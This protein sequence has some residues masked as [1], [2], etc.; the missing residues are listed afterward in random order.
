MVQLACVDG[1]QRSCALSLMLRERV[2]R[3]A[4]AGS[5]NVRHGVALTKSGLWEV[6]RGDHGEVQEMCQTDSDFTIT[7][8]TIFLTCIQHVNYMSSYLNVCRR[9]CSVGGGEAERPAET[10]QS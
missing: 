9:V 3:R 5:L 4:C 6:W 10:P 7:I 2:S 1:L 8:T